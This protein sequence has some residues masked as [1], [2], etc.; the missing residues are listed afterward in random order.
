MIKYPNECHH[1]D[2]IFNDNTKEVEERKK[3]TEHE[4]WTM[5]EEEQKGEYKN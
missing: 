4:G 2:S 1:L 5:E 3:R